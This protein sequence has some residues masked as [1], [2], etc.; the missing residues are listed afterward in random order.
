MFRLPQQLLYYIK[1]TSD[2]QLFLKVF[3]DFVFRN[4]SAAH[5]S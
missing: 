3:F 1:A 4:L 2:C 5:L